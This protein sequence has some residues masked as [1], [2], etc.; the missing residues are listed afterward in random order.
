MPAGMESEEGM[1]LFVEA[2]KAVLF[3]VVEGITE[4]LPISWP[5]RFSYIPTIRMT[6]TLRRSWRVRHSVTCIK[7][8][9]IVLKT[10]KDVCPE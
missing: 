3:G 8:S 2:L 1:N 10:M 4:W 9:S 5:F 6:E 7:Y